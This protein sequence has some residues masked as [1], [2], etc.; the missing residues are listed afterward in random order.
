M[1]NELIAQALLRIMKNQVVITK[2]LG[3]DGTRWKSDLHTARNETQEFIRDF[4][5]ELDMAKREAIEEQYNKEY[6]AKH[7]QAAREGALG[8]SVGGQDE[9]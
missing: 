8:S 3:Y 7:Q 5:I 1:T 6:F 9:Q 4:Q 2:E